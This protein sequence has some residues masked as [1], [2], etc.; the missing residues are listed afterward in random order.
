MTGI[1]RNVTKHY[2]GKEHSMT[3]TMTKLLPATST[4]L[5]MSWLSSGHYA[6]AN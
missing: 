3:E 4:S 1:S 6:E 5:A 2:G